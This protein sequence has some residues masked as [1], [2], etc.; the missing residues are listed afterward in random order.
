MKHF[1]R[2]FAGATFLEVEEMIASGGMLILIFDACATF[3]TLKPPT[4]LLRMS[5]LVKMIKEKNSLSY[6]G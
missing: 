6:I 3:P 2:F 1:Y 4:S 5:R